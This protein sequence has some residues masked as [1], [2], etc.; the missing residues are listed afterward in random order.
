[1]WYTYIKIRNTKY[2]GD[3]EMLANEKIEKL[4]ELG[5]KRWS[6]AGKDRL[7][8]ND[9]GLKLAELDIDRYNTGNISSATMAGDKISNSKAGKIIPAVS[10]GYIDLESGKVVIN[11]YQA[12]DEIDVASKLIEKN[13]IEL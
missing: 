11:N 8:L 9:A 4:I 13:L 1:M 12:V 3:H 10:Q 7:Y 6:K 2:K 5:A